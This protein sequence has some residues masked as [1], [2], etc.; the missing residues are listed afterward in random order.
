MAEPITLYGDGYQVRDILDVSDAVAAYLA[1]WRN[2]DAIAGRAFNLGGGPNNA[3]SLRLLLDH[4]GDLLGRDVDLAFSDWRAGDQR[5]FVADTRA[6]DAALGLGGKVDWRSGVA[7]SAALARRSRGIEMPIAQPAESGGM[8]GARRLLVTADASAASGNMRSNWRGRSY[9]TATRRHLLCLVPRRPI[10]NAEPLTAS[11][12]SGWWKPGLQLDWLAPDA[13]T[14]TSAGGEIARLAATLGV[15]IVQLNQPAFAAGVR[16]PMPVAAVAHSC[17]GTWWQAVRGDEL[18]A[19]RLCVQ[20]RPDAVRS[21]RGWHGDC[22]E[23]GL[24]RGVAVTLCA[25]GFA[26]YRSQWPDTPRRDHWRAA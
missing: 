26:L 19:R 12:G 25:S 6:V 14:L 21:C 2:I 23:P 9:G 17:V 20:D 8:S 16:F 11:L 1:A 10:A 22:A 5:Y 3:V 13:A 24:R 18:R 15:D 4:V 7:N